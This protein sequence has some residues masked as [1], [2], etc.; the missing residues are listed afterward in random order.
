MWKNATNVINSDSSKFF[1]E[2][3]VED[4]KAFD[5]LAE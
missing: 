2:N 5:V 3:N 1:T 4:N